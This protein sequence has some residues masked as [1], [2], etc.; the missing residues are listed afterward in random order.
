MLVSINFLKYK[1]Y[2]PSLRPHKGNRFTNNFARASRLAFWYICLPSLHDYDKKVSFWCHF[3]GG[4]KHS[5]SRWNKRDKVWSSSNTLFVWR[6]QC[7]EL[8]PSLLLELPQVPSRERGVKLLHVVTKFK[9][10]VIFSPLSKYST[11]E[12]ENSRT[13]DEGNIR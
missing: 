13:S 5:T 11:R 12:N 6:F 10:S 4:R 1:I 9:W 7:T 3:C 2:K 8:S